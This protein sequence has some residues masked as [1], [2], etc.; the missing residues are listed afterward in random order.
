[1]SKDDV[2]TG[3]NRERER[4]RQHLKKAKAIVETWPE[5]RRSMLGWRVLGPRNGSIGASGSPGSGKVSRLEAV[6]VD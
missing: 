6:K 2:E 3:A 4:L 5:E 1:M